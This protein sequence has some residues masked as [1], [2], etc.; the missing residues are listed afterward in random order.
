MDVNRQA[1]ENGI[2]KFY[3]ERALEKDPDFKVQREAGEETLRRAIPER[4]EKQFRRTGNKY[5]L[6]DAE[7]SL[8]FED[9]GDSL[10]AKSSDERIAHALVGIAEAREWSNIKVKGSEEFRRKMWLEGSL[11]GLKVTGYDPTEQDRKELDKRQESTKSGVMEKGDGS[12]LISLSD[13][14][15]TKEN[16]KLADMQKMRRLREEN[17]V[18]GKELKGRLV[19]HGE[20]AFEFD[21]KN[22][23]SYFVQIDNGQGPKTVWGVD[24]QRAVQDSGAKKGDEIRLKYVGRESVKV[25]EPLKDETGKVIGEREKD[26][27]RNAW[28]AE[29]TEAQRDKEAVLLAT[30]KAVV[31]DRIKKPETRA[32]VIGNIMQRIDERNKAGQSLPDVQVFDRKA[33]PSVQQAAT[34]T[35]R[36]SKEKDQGKEIDKGISR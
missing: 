4:V 27:H 29:K 11:H 15:L 26:A 8:A 28:H 20:A 36:D 7:K 35:G 5:Y 1:E 10:I 33:A 9:R 23:S 17:G 34:Q 18:T 32:A 2:E 16:R 30:A 31:D 21:E 24:L 3:A 13:T 19:E 14:D 22:K 25:K 6:K 12:P